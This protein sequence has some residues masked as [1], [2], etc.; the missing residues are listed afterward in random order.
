MKE[1]IE[2][3]NANG[4]KLRVRQWNPEQ[5]TT[6]VLVH[7]YPDSS[8]VWDSTVAE[9]AD[10]YHVV[11]YD[12]RGAGESDA[13][14]HTKAYELEHLAADFRA[15]IDFVSPDKPIHLV[16]HDW[17]SI[18][19]WESVTDPAMADRIASYTTISGPCLDHAGYWIT[20]RLKSG[21]PDQ[22]S[23][24]ANQLL[25]SWYIGAFHLPVLAPSLWRS[26]LDKL[27]PSILA[28]VEG[29]TEHIPNPTQRRDG[30][31][32]V[33]LY[34]ANFSKRVLSPQEK[35]T[36]VPVQLVV[37]TKDNYVSTELF[38]D[39][40]QWAPKL[41][42]FDVNAG[43]WLQVSK[44]AM[45]AGYIRRFV[46]FI[47]AGAEES[48]MPGA[49][50]RAQV[51]GPRK[52]Y[53]GKL[54][55]VTGAGSGIGRETLL[56][57]AA[58]GAEVVGVDINQENLDRSIELAAALGVPAHGRKMDVGDKRAWERFAAWVEKNLGA[59]D[60]VVNNAGIAIAGRF[61]D[62]DTEDWD[63]ILKVNVWSVIH[64]SRLFGKQML[65]AGKTGQIVNVASAAAF[66][67]QRVF[68][69]Y[70][71][72]KAAVRMLSDCMRADLAEDGIHVITVCPGVINTGITDRAKFVG[73]TESEQDEKRAHATKMYSRRNLG[74][75]A[76]AKDILKALN[77]NKDEVITGIEAYGMNWLGRFTPG[78]ARRLAQ[79]DV[80][81]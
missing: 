16:A 33:N 54:A 67:P 10:D 13:P 3:I 81:G 64:G 23:K 47:E 71:T 17:G 58:Q 24:V 29:V 77:S 70:S 46:D 36:D 37:P 48:K 79:L 73:T 1:Q 61:L 63:K 76:V 41:W 69:A 20:Q 5:P 7:G 25:H 72:T 9:L 68:S 66:A 42:R 80:T 56:A 6:I 60:I 21:K 78:L 22:V 44:P 45:V 34:R 14:K 62:T 65:D 38:E 35:R 15:V 74:P 31:V 2:N 50:R 39:L 57:L 53:S 18:Q 55:I 8:H 32:G 4:L 12:V 75:E 26:G 19:S 30:A 51:T 11:V 49:L 40:H 27:W 43:H 28:R 52:P 59:P